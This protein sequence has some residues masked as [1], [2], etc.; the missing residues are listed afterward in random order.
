MV[1]LEE[2]QKTSFDD[3]FLA[4]VARSLN[5]DEAKD[6]QVFLDEYP[7]G[8]TI[9]QLLKVYVEEALQEK[10]D[11][12]TD[13]MQAKV[14][15]DVKSRIKPMLEEWYPLVLIKKGDNYINLSSM[16]E[17]LDSKFKIKVIVPLRNY[18]REEDYCF[19]EEDGK[20]YFFIENGVVEA[21]SKD[22]EDGEYDI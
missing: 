5:W 21:F 14:T 11:E 7:E 15:E 13:E 9:K 2:L 8:I 17:T 10:N 4:I 16:E 3:F 12:I 22:Y 1:T 20:V 18:C 19:E 6:L